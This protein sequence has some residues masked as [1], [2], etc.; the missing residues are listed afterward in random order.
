MNALLKCTGKGKGLTD[1]LDGYV[2]NPLL[3]KNYDVETPE[4]GWFDGEECVYSLAKA[5]GHVKNND[6]TKDAV[7]A[8]KK[9]YDDVAAK[10]E[11]VKKGR[12]TRGAKKS[13]DAAVVVFDEAAEAKKAANV[14]AALAAYDTVL[15]QQSLKLFNGYKTLV[16]DADAKAELGFVGKKKKRVKNA[17]EAEMLHSTK[18]GLLRE[19]YGK[20]L[21]GAALTLAALD[22]VDRRG[23]SLVGKLVNFVAGK[24]KPAPAAAAA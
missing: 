6:A 7:A 11:P 22:Y 23:D 4:Q 3:G 2:F 16:K 17:S 19:H 5:R 1:A 14:A 9:A 20:A 18:N 24:I 10:N 13:V 8:A 15:N 12:P 21:V